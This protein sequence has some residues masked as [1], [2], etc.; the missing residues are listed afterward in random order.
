MD[1]KDFRLGLLPLGVS[2]RFAFEVVLVAA[3]GFSLIYAGALKQALKAER[4]QHREYVAQVTAVAVAQSA[5]AEQKEAEARELSAQIEVKGREHEE[6]IRAA[7]ADARR[8]VR[9]AGRPGGARPVPAVAGGAPDP[10]GAA[11][12]AGVPARLGEGVADEACAV[13]TERYLLWQ[14][15]YESLRAQEAGRE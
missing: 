10:A 11:A 9:D 4:A 7:F 5:L 3:L 13:L 1:L 2:P 14:N 8:R 12:D 15:F 6:A